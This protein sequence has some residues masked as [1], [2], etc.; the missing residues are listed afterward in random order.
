M[1]AKPELSYC[2]TYFS[3][4]LSDAIPSSKLGRRPPSLLAHLFNFFPSSISFPDYF[5][6]HNTLRKMTKVKVREAKLTGMLLYHH[7]TT[8]TPYGLSQA[9]W[10]T[11]KR[12]RKRQQW[13]AK[14][15][16]FLNLKWNSPQKQMEL[17]FRAGLSQEHVVLKVDTS[18][19]LGSPVLEYAGRLG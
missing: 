3:A 12:G 14:R 9:H 16:I 6:F 1:Q 18:S 5:Y 11:T 10:T 13:L 15:S 17:N 4:Y 7:F 8:G 2:H 19:A